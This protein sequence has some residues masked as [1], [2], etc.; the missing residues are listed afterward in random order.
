MRNN[1]IEELRDLK[2]PV[3]EQ[4]WEAIVHDKRYVKKFGRKAGL[5]P[6]GRA[7]LITGAA[8]VLL[9][10][11]ILIITLSH[12]TND[13]VQDN[14]PVAQTTAPQQET[15]NETTP[16]VS[17][18]TINPVV[19]PKQEETL[20]ILPSASSTTSRAATHEQSTL[21]AVAEARIPANNHPAPAAK[22][23]TASVTTSQPTET[24]NIK[25]KKTSSPIV[26][27]DRKSQP[28]V[29][30][31]RPQTAVSFTDDSQ[32]TVEKSLEQPETEAEE[33][34]I[35][36]AF[37]PNGDGLNDLFKVQANFVPNTFEMS[38]FNRKGEL[39]FLSQD[40]GI[41]WD[42]QFHGQTLPNGVYVCIIKYTDREGKKQKR[43]GQVMLLP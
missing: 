29:T 38:I 42:G 21:A 28:D 5:S 26:S 36:T 35:P 30:E 14:H 32:P 17:Q 20:Q 39:M 10:V 9:T 12:K 40:M 18:M 41:G 16:A 37:T 24:V 33:F 31:N 19:E 8:A 27:S 22:P 15:V 1:P 2:A 34:F 43:Q 11:P 7:A 13:T 6:K 3:T 25:P 23:A 4:E